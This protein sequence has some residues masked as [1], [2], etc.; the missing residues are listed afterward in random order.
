MDQEVPS[1]EL[2]SVVNSHEKPFM[3]IDRNYRIVAVNEAYE[4]TFGH[5]D[6]A[7]V[8]TKCHEASYRSAIPC[9]HSGKACPHDRMFASDGGSICAQHQCDINNGR[10]RVRMSAYPLMGSNGVLYMGES[11]DEIASPEDRR[12][13]GERMV[14]EAPAFLAC[15]QQLEVAAGSEAP[16]L[17]QGETG[18]GKEV[19]AEYIHAH[20]A[21]ADRPF[22]VVDSAVSAENLFESAMFGHVNGAFPGSGEHQGLIE[23]ADGGTVFLDEICDLPMA[24]QAKLLRVLECGQYRRVG[25][26][27]ACKADVRI[28]CASNRHLL[29]SVQNGLFREDLYYRIACLNIRLPP[30]RERIDDVPALARNLLERINRT[31]RG[32]YQLHPDS[33]EEL[34]R[35][36]YPGNVRELR[37]VL[38]IA[39]THC[40]DRQINAGLIRSVMSNLPQTR[41][42]QEGINADDTQIATPAQPTPSQPPS[43]LQDLEA[44][45][46]RQLL[47][48]FDG[49]RKKVADFLGISERTVYRKLNKLN[50]R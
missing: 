21:R 9:S 37:N 8:G 2:E 7:A 5:L 29:E 41:Q 15:R 22:Q 14:G 47:E 40:Q 34:K 33:Y 48:R 24:Q 32:S 25:A 44:D 30:L 43:S 50:L 49:N 23:L 27:Q 16:V 3:I 38:F 6:G 31:M 42:K 4:K 35:Y 26:K 36:P 11:I 1:I 12:R 28:I 45:H 39:A 17:L 46:I 18:T 20:S 13:N 10:H 19:A